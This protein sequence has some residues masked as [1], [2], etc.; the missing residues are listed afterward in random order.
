MLHVVTKHSGLNTAKREVVNS[1]SFSKCSSQEL[2]IVIHQSSGCALT[3][4]CSSMTSGIRPQT[5]K[6]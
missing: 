5:S 3:L 6:N 2:V 4:V 1:M